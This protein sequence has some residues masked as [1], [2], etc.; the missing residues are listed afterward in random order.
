MV[1]VPLDVHRF[2]AERITL[3]QAALLW[4][5]PPSR[6]PILKQTLKVISGFQLQSALI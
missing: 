3:P 5:S 6:V 1:C 4:G 2:I